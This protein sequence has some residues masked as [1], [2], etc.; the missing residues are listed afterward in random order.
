MGRPAPAGGTSPDL[1]EKAGAESSYFL[2]ASTCF[3]SYLRPREPPPP[4]L[5]GESEAEP[6]T[7][8]R[9]RVLSA[10]ARLWGGGH[11]RPPSCRAP[12]SPLSL[13]GEQRVAAAAARYEPAQT[14]GPA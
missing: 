14:C 3:H 11:Q 4:L 8:G 2:G 7:V 1:M 9:H 12:A 5:D 13:W 10:C 6:A